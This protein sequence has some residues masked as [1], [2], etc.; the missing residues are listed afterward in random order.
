VTIFKKLRPALLPL[1][2]IYGLVVRL[3]NYFFDKGIFHSVEFT[4]PVFCI[5]NLSTGGTGKTPMVERVISSLSGKYKIAVLSRGYKR[6]TRGFLLAEDNSVANDIG[7]EPMQIHQKFKNITVAVSEDRLVAIPQILQ[8]RPETEIIILDD[9]FQHRSAR[10]GLNILLTSYSNPYSRDCFLPAGNLRDSRR[11]SSRADIIVVTKC[12]P[13]LTFSEGDELREELNLSARQKIF[14]TS[15]QHQVPRHLF[16][17]TEKVPDKATSVL[18]VTGIADAAPLVSA[19]KNG[20][21]ILV[22]LSYGDHHAYS[23][24]DIIRIKRLFNEM[25]GED[26]MIITTEKDGVRL[27]QFKNQLSDLPIFVLPME[28]WFLFNG[29]PIFD[30]LLLNFI[31]QKL[32]GEI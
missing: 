3:R 9:A 5:G 29:L 30:D 13:S 27:F 20:S 4:L 32:S 19:L 31:E 1:A 10:A 24:K 28:H 11:S 26:K 22:E 6:K 18:L 8:E 15:I 12:P 7:D 23:L 17:L 2:W 25:R 21:R 14:F 16:Q